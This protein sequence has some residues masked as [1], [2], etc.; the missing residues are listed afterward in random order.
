MLRD[1]AKPAEILT[2]V[3]GAEG[4][5]VATDARHTLFF[6]QLRD[7]NFPVA[8]VA[9][10]DG[11]GNCQ[12]TA[13]ILAESYGGHFSDSG[14]S[15]FWIEFGRN[16]SNSEEGWYARP[17]SC[18]ER[19]KFGD[20]VFG[21]R[22]V[23]DDFVVFEGGDAEDTTS[24]L[25]YNRL[26]K[27]PSATPALPRVIKEHPDPTRDVVSIAGQT[28]V[29]FSVSMGAAGETGLYLHGPLEQN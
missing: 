23:G 28:W 6:R 5:H 1:R 2:L 18:G 26:Q 27:T 29:M 19:T 14:R 24:W 8:F 15:V 11:S 7:S 17:E 12:L 21:Y 22:L 4:I 16:Q 9:R 13:D 20:Y 25:Q 10:N 3:A